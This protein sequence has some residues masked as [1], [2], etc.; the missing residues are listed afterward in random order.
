MLLTTL[1]ITTVL[2]LAVETHK[3]RHMAPIAIGGALFVGHIAG[4]P[5]TGASI[6]PARSFG[7]EIVSGFKGH[8]WIYYIGPFLGAFLAN[9]VYRL[10]KFLEYET[11][12]PG[13]DFDDQEALLFNP[14]NPAVHASDVRRP[15]VVPYT[16]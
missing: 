1:L 15:I 4:I 10:M 14:P 5:W 12:N 16:V 9:G 11:S 8:D 6:N 3:A 7:P 2:F 13:Q